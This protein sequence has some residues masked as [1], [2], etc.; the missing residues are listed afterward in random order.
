MRSKHM[1]KAQMTYPKSQTIDAG[2]TISS[3]TIRVHLFLSL[4]HSHSF[5]RSFVLLVALKGDFKWKW[6]TTL[7][8]VT[9]LFHTHTYTHRRANKWHFVSAR[10]SLGT[11]DQQQNTQ[12][13][14]VS[15]WIICDCSVTLVVSASIL[16]KLTCHKIHNERTNDRRC[17]TLWAQKKHGV[18]LVCVR[19]SRPCLH[20]KPK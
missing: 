8:E 16:W 15:A 18:I 11:T 1:H 12:R 19:W 17:T 3:S 9:E 7:A 20:P 4:S 14:A 2:C 10:R 13:N 6:W 5:S